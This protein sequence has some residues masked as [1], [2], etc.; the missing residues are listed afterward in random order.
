MR[1]IM[2]LLLF[3]SAIFTL[4][5]IATAQTL[6]PKGYLDVFQFG[7][8]KFSKDVLVNDIPKYTVPRGSTKLLI[9]L[10]GT[11]VTFVEIG[12][13]NFLGLGL[14]GGAVLTDDGVSAIPTIPVTSFSIG[15]NIYFSASYAYHR[16]HG[17]S[18][19]FSFGPE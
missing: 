6:K 7:T 3:V 19:G 10:I 1:R 11:H 18:I 2:M 16:G 8:V 17:Y 12:R 14:S 15:N 13:F 5:G 9:S 4:P